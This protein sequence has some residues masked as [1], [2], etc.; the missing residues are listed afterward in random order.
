MAFAHG[1]KD[2]VRCALF[3]ATLAVAIVV[4]IDSDGYVHV[5]VDTDGGGYFGLGYSWDEARWDGAGWDFIVE[6]GIC[7]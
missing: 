6:G 7:R 5:D 3:I 1:G 4:G 2:E